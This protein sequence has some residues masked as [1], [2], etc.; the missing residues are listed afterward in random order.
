MPMHNLMEYSENYLKT[1][2]SLWQYHRD[3]PFL[4]DNGNFIDA[5]IDPDSA[6]F[7]SKQKITGQKGNDGTKGNQIM[8]RL[9]YLSNFWRTLEIQLTNWA[10]K[11]FLTWSDKY[12]IITRDYLD[13][14]P[15]IAITL[16]FRCDFISPR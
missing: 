14:E 15:K 11:I 7:Q 3:E 12:I 6:S 16:C 2:E 4:G 10:I 9:K 8:A 5:P 1:S 13:K